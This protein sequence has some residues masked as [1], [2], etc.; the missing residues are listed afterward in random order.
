MRISNPKNT[1]VQR[2]IR[3]RHSR[4]RKKTGLFVI[5]G[6]REIE[7]AQQA[8]VTIEEIY[9]RVEPDP[10]QA[11]QQWLQRARPELPC[12]W[13][14]VDSGVFSKLQYGD[15][16]DGVIA[17]AKIQRTSLE[18]LIVSTNPFVVIAEQLQKPGNL[19][20]LLRTADATGVEAVLVADA[21]VDLFNP[22]VIRAS[23][24]AAFTVPTVNVSASE[25]KSWCVERGIAIY[26]A[27]LD[28]DQSY[29]CGDYCPPTALAL[30]NEARGLSSIWQSD[31]IVSVRLPMDGF[32]D[33][34]NV[35]VTAGV[36]LYEVQ[37][38]RRAG[39]SS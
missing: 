20:A 37:R 32:V 18:D 14:E 31:D 25:A 6:L 27:R 1:R 12:E 11:T 38:Q 22:N 8:G 7:R 33:S 19:G 35:S 28:G 34:L 3:L 16:D 13:I 23:M 36:L 29:E 26:A 24:G 21:D 39:S 17:V 30:G 2:T 5:D 9:C 15:R 4:E 10:P